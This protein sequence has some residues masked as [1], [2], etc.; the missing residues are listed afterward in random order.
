MNNSKTNILPEHDSAKT[1]A[2]DFSSYFKSKTLSEMSLA[3]TSALYSSM[4]IVTLR[5]HLRHLLPFH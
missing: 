2:D 1:L 3:M 4:M 5:F